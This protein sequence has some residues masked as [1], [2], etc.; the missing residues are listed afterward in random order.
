LIHLVEELELLVVLEKVEHQEEL[1][2]EVLVFLEVHLLDPE[3]PR[4]ED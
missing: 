2:M 3:E 1:L 4:G